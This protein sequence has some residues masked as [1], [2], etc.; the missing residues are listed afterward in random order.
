MSVN[1]RSRNRDYLK[2]HLLEKRTHVL[3]AEQR[4]TTGERYTVDNSG[5]PLNTVR[6]VNLHSVCFIILDEQRPSRLASCIW[7]D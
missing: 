2:A 5:W 7:F 6:K 3:S 4:A 1:Q